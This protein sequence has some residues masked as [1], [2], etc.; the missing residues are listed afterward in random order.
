MWLLTPF[1]FV[2]IVQKP[3]DAQQGTLTVRARV[4]EDLESLRHCYLPGLGEIHES[5]SNDY[6]FRA[7][8]PRRQVSAALSAVVDDLG[9]S[10][11]KSQVSKEQG[12]AR[13]HLYH[14]VWSV[15]YRLQ[16]THHVG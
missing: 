14:D 7:Q 8:A 13:A 5:H 12:A 2:S 1:G 10:N 16:E 3:G 9:Y 15:L 11:F 6:R 4:R